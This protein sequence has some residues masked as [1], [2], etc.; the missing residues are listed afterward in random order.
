MAHT[1][2][3]ELMEKLKPHIEGSYINETDF[4]RHPERAQKCFTPAS[5]ARIESGRGR[6]DPE[7]M[8]VPPFEFR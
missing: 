6:Y 8:F 4:I 5:R 3:D 7:G 2:S 1:W